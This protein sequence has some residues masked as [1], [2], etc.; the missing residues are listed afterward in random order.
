MTGQ[1]A[2][3]HEHSVTLH[4]D[5]PDPNGL[6]LADVAGLILGMDQGRFEQDIPSVEP[7]PGR[8]SS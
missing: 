8:S 7:A 6:F 3:L 2:S 4:H 1:D 5:F